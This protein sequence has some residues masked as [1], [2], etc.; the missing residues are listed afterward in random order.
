MQKYVY[1][2]KKGVKGGFSEHLICGVNA[3]WVDDHKIVG[4]NMR[5]KIKLLVFA[6]IMGFVFVINQSIA[7]DN[8]RPDSTSVVPLKNVIAMP[9]QKSFL[10]FQDTFYRIPFPAINYPDCRDG[11]GWNV[12]LQVSKNSLG[13]SCPPN[14]IP[15]A[16]ASLSRVGTNDGQDLREVIGFGLLNFQLIDQGNTYVIRYCAFTWYGGGQGNADR[17]WISLTIFC[18]SKDR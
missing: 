17:A 10:L 1:T 2:S 5:E 11:N 13:G 15:R 16:V 18:D 9:Y 12:N 14:Y 7:A 4:K 6:V 8:P 3:A